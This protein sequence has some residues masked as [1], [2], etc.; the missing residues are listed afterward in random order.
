MSI[1]REKINGQFLQ[2]KQVNEDT[3][4]IL[5][6]NI[7]LAAEML[8]QCLLNGKKLL[9][10]GNG[11]SASASQ[12]FSS[13]LLNRYE[14]NRPALPAVSLTT[15]CSTITSISN[16]DDFRKIFSRQIKAIG[17][18]GDVLIVFT[19]SGESPNVIEAIKA[20][21]M[22]NL[23]VLALSGKDGGVLPDVLKDNDLEL[24][25]PSMSTPRIQELHLLITHCFCEL[26]DDHLFGKTS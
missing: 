6:D 7:L 16:D 11:G 25:V 23:T 19:T 24:R 5:A 8:I 4:S 1:A 15:D 10:C 22:R 26:I 3:L 9:C 18:S 14:M 12:H 21:Q 13:E 2:N 17:Q 20:A